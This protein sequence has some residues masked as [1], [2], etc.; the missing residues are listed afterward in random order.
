MKSILPTLFALLLLSAPAQAKWGPM[1]LPQ[2]IDFAQVIVVAEFV[3]EEQRKDSDIA[4]TQIAVLKS[5][6]IISGT[7]GRDFKVHGWASPG[8]CK[9]QYVFPPK[10]GVKYLLFL[11]KT[12]DGYRVVNGHFGALP[13]AEGKISWFSNASVG[14]T[15][16]QR[17]A[18]ELTV[19]V[20]A[21]E[22]QEAKLKKQ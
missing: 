22:E 18:T 13:V 11:R 21:I 3:D 4:T 10:K 20:R 14:Q 16:S 12:Q 5:H 1:N 7:I 2:L 6:K 9:P 17:K 19:A 8:I 15:M